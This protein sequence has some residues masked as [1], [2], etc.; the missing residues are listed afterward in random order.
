MTNNKNGKLK[1]DKTDK[2]NKAEVVEQRTVIHE[3]SPAQ[4]M[5]IQ[6]L[7]IS[8]LESVKRMGGAYWPNVVADMYRRTV[9]VNFR[10][11]PVEKIEAHFEK[12]KKAV[13]DLIE[14]AKRPVE[15]SLS[16]E[17]KHEK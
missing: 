5:Q 2:T 14:F 7:A 9:A 6:R 1:T 15:S 10:N 13:L 8:S 4:H 11:E 16:N 17:G 3:P 12:M